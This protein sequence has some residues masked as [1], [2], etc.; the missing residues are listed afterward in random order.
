MRGCS[1]SVN[2]R[3]AA[4]PVGV[5]FGTLVHTVLEATDFAATDLDAELAEHVA[6]AQ[7]RRSLDLGDADQVVQGLRAAIS[8]PLG[9]IVGGVRLRDIARADRLD[10]LAFE[11][12]LAGGDAPTGRLTLDA[13]AVRCGSICPPAIRWPVTRRGSRTRR[14][15]SQVRGF[16]TGSIDL[17]IRLDGRRGSRSSTTRRTGSARPAS[18]CT[19]AHYRPDVLA[20]RDEPRALRA[21]GAAL[22]GR[23]A[24][25]PP[26]AAAGVRR[27]TVIWLE[28]STCSFAGWPATRTR[29]C[30]RGGRR[31]RSC[32]R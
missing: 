22:H 9:R 10:E 6:A 23:A 28:C 14:S 16:L 21:P 15:A 5:D 1:S 8:T 24:P 27:R 19:L 12:P 17:V 29:A 25:L 4:T 31:D 26:L 3:S 13:I 30:S 18:R 32:S 20:A 7:L 2:R 11:L